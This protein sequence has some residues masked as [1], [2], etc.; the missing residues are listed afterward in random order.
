[1]SGNDFFNRIKR[2]V[3]AHGFVQVVNLAIRVCEVPLFLYF[4]TVVE[5][6][7]WLMLAAIPY[8]FTVADLGITGVAQREMTM[9]YNNVGVKKTQAIYSTASFFLWGCCF[10]LE[11]VL[12]VVFYAAKKF[13]CLVGININDV[14]IYVVLILIA[15]VFV[16]FQCN[17][18]YGWY[19]CFKKHPTGAFLNGLILL[20]EF[21][22]S[23]LMLVL[24]YG[25]LGVAVGMLVGR[26]VGYFLMVCVILNSEKLKFAMFFSYKFFSKGILKGLSKPSLA[27][28]AFP[29]SEA[30]NIQGTRFLVGWVL[31]PHALA[32]YSSMR[33]LC[34]T[35][36]QPIVIVSRLVEPELAI[37]YGNKDRD[38]VI[39]IFFSSSK[40]S[41][42]L[43]VFICLVVVMLGEPVFNYWTRGQIVFDDVVFICL[44]AASGVHGLWYTAFLVPYAT[45]QHQKLA[46]GTIALNIG[47]I[48]GG[49]ALMSVAGEVSVPSMLLIYEFLM[50]GFVIDLTKKMLGVSVIDFFMNFFSGFRKN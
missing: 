25:I 19:C 35:A 6:G 10:V 12:F 7:Q 38:L 47:V 29:M 11:S 33:T 41:F 28:L 32:A 50:A 2:G 5:Y 23:V 42:W 8:Y 9:E 18:I 43:S 15:Q 17:L 37:A 1:M 34:R 40:V 24:G 39:K 45:N 30:I 21:L 4:L 44:L 46:F 31:G 49:F 22:M 14:E 13:D 48:F 26:V 20:S 36:V 3:F 27:A 16:V